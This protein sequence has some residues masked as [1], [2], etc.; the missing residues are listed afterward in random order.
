MNTKKLIYMALG[1]LLMLISCAQDEPSKRELPGDGNRIYFR[2]YLPTVTLSRAGEVTTANFKECQVTCF[3]PDDNTL[4]DSSTGTMTPYFTDI[5]FENDGTGRFFSKGDEEYMWPNPNSTMHFFA[6]YPS[7][8]DMK[9]ISGDT[10]FN[11][12][13]ASSLPA[14][15]TAVLDYHLE[16]FRVHAD[17]ADHVDFLTAY[18]AGSLSANGD[19]GIKLDFK[20][21]LA[22]VELTAWV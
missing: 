2:S 19:A 15:G 11:L 13:N 6:Y 4:I 7:V 17:I 22:R 21:Q 8:G 10:L 9:K 5:C 12:V 3:N 14:D 1:I 16:R 20:T 18:S